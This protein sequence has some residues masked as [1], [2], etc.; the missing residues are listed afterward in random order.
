[1]TIEIN[2][3]VDYLSN[4]IQLKF[5]LKEMREEAEPF[6]F[7]VSDVTENSFS[8][9][10]NDVSKITGYEIYGWD[11]VNGIYSIDS[12]LIDKDKPGFLIKD[13]QS[14]LIYTVNLKTNYF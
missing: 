13:L 3:G 4:P 14:N 2:E 11:L 10:W 8:L 12:G 1:E 6:H 9:R 7:E 5:R